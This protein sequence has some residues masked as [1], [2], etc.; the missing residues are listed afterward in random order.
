MSQKQASFGDFFFLE[1]WSGEQVS[2]E[3]CGIKNL[4]IPGSLS[5]AHSTLLSE[6]FQT[7]VQQIIMPSAYFHHVLCDRICCLKHNTFIR[8]FEI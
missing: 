2:Y 7:L 3:P 1:L 5:R 8:Q 6:L 4:Y